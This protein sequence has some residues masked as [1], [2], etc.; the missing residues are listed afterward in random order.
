MNVFNHRNGAYLDIDDARIYF[1]QLGAQDAPTLI[2]L[3]GGLGHI[4]TFNTITPYLAEHWRLIGIDSRGQGKSTL[5]AAG[6][7]YQRLQQDVE[8]VIE[9]LGLTSVSIIG[10]SDGGIVGLRLAA[11]KQVQVD[12]LV[13]LGAHW[14]LNQDDP[15]RG[16][17][18]GI[19]AAKWRGLFAEDVEQ[20]E[21][22]NPE[23]DFA[24]LMDAVKALWLDTSEA[25]YPG[26]SVS[27]ITAPLLV[28]RGDEDLLV[29]RI[30]A[31]ELA[32]QVPGAQLLN[33]AFADHSPH[34]SRPQWLMPMLEAFLNPR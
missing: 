28:V 13:T 26:A 15:T 25:G 12:K 27:T 4:E 34:E 19:T 9:H 8:R 23:P 7:T 3:H 32:D 1:E 10:H 20:Y 22:L 29:S 2:L 6:L 30:N 33:L 16:L 5:G 17:Y 24:H 14:A 21:S 11:S 31:L 18:A